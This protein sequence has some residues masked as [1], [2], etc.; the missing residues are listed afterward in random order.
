VT[1]VAHAHGWFNRARRIPAKGWSAGVECRCARIVN[2]G[3]HR[4]T[5]PAAEESN[6]ISHETDMLGARHRLL[7]P[8]PGSLVRSLQDFLTVFHT[9][10]RGRNLSS[11]NYLAC[12]V[13][14]IRTPDRCKTDAPY[15]AR[16]GGQR[17]RP[18]GSDHDQAGRALLS[19]R[20]RRG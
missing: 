1:V 8:D 20:R 5:A 18:H 10:W 3:F 15:G 7:V 17:T 14:R 2:D 9:K 4:W 13:Q 19:R 11:F 12:R 16:K 6:V